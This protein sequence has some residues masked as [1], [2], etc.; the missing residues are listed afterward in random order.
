MLKTAIYGIVR[1][2][3]DLIGDF[4]WWWGALVLVF[5]LVSAV[6]GSGSTP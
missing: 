6:L 2:V 3:F 4:P 5:G 1:V